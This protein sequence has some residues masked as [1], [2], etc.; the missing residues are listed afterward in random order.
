MCDKTLGETMAK[1]ALTAAAVGAL[2]P[3]CRRPTSRSSQYLRQSSAREQIVNKP[4]FVACTRGNSEI[5]V[6][7]KSGSQINLIKESA[8]DYFEF[9]VLVDDFGFC[10]YSC[11]SNVL[12]TSLIDQTWIVGLTQFTLFIDGC[13]LCFDGLVVDDDYFIDDSHYDVIAGAPFM[14]QN[15]VSVRPSKQQIMF[16]DEVMYYYDSSSLQSVSAVPPSCVH[17]EEDMMN[18]NDT[19]GL[20]ECDPFPNMGNRD[21]M[22]VSHCVMDTHDYDGHTLGNTNTAVDEYMY[23][24]SASEDCESMTGDDDNH[25]MVEN[26]DG[27]VGEDH[28]INGF[29]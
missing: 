7:L 1:A 12:V 20:V 24:T 3:K 14:E 23:N 19:T 26:E 8:A 22:N 18:G 27:E 29:R 13:E 16:G 17:G 5:S 9:D 6:E 28:G 21:E 2:M 15:D 25:H 11:D 4:C 10:D